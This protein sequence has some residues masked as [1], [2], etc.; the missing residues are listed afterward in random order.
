VDQ[1]GVDQHPVET[2]GFGTLVTEIELT[3]TALQNLFLFTE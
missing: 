1:T 2:P 3:S